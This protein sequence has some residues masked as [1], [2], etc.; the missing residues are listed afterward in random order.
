MGNF[1]K[2]KFTV[3][4]LVKF[5]IGVVL[6]NHGGELFVFAGHYAG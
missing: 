1:Q 6:I 4:H 2:S 5:H 3:L